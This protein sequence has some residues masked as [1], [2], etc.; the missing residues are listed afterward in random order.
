MYG[1]GYIFDEPN[2]RQLKDE[3]LHDDPEKLQNLKR[4]LHPAL[5]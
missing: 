3:Q 2:K 4:V 5:K 1:G